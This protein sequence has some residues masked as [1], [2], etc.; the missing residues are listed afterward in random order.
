MYN[1]LCCSSGL[2]IRFGDKQQYIPVILFLLQEKVPVDISEIAEEVMNVAMTCEGNGVGLPNI[3][4]CWLQNRG[5]PESGK[6]LN[7][8]QLDK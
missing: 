7:L 4:S 2:L 1:V 3:L 8:Y 6:S 5:N